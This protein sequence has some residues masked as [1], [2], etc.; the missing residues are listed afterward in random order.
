MPINLR[1][2]HHPQSSSVNA[3]HVPWLMCVASEDIIHF[4]DPQQVPFN[5]YSLVA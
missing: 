1:D 3:H 2:A 5:V 4:R